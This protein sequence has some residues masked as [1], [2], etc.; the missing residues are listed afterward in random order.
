MPANAAPK[1]KGA[2]ELIFSHKSPA[3]KL[4]GKAVMPTAVWNKP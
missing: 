2:E 3:I 4:A 1:K